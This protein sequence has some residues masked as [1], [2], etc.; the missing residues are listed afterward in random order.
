[1]LIF[2]IGMDL[3][4]GKTKA[5]GP[6]SKGPDAFVFP[7]VFLCFFVSSRCSFA[8]PLPGIAGAAC[9]VT[10]LQG[11]A[12]QG[13]GNVLVLLGALTGRD[14]I[15]GASVLASAELGEADQSGQGA[16]IIRTDTFNK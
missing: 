9:Q 6:L 10:W 15:G 1:M 2:K 14:G 7:F 3:L 8:G 11:S 13:P 16:G 5:S 12:A 4:R